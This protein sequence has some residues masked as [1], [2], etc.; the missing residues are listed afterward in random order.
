MKA[1][2][3]IDFG[4]TNTKVTAVDVENKE[5]IG[6]A[7]AFTT[8]KTDVTQGLDNALEK[9]CE[10]VGR[11]NFVE[12]YACSSAAG[13]L[14]MLAVGLVPD[15][16]AEAAKR[17]ALNAGAKV[18][19]TF[20][21]RLND[22]D[23]KEIKSIDPDILLLTGGTDG[24]NSK[25]INYN[26]QVIANIENDFP[27]I[28]AGNRDVS[29]SVA[30][31]LEKQGRDVRVCENVMPEF[32]VLNIEPAKQTIKDLFL[33]RIV[34]AKG[35]TK[36]ESLQNGIL[37]PT[38]SAVLKAVSLLSEG[39]PTNKGLG[40]FMLA[41]IGGA[42]TDVYSAS[43]GICAKT[44]VSF[45]GLPE[46][47]AKRTVEGDLGVRYTLKYLVE[48]VGVEQIAKFAGVEASL[49]EEYL[50]KIEQDP[51][52]IAM[53]G[54][55]QNIDYAFSYF[56]VRLATNRHVGR[57]ETRYTINGVVFVQTGKDLTKLDKVIGTGGPIINSVNPK[58]VLLASLFDE[59]DESVLKPKEFE[60]FLD[61]DYILA[62]M[63]L[64]VEKYP[65]V[66][67]EIMKK[68]IVKI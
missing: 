52:V 42:T 27:V 36:I 40:E 1:V 26:A 3:L 54:E 12:K 9:L 10:K 8:V 48:E 50:D 4:S 60:C 25:V 63:G 46:E 18:L 67:L 7:R 57:V 58:G 64:L 2:L 28:V 37:M 61:K 59:S 21:Y 17:A 56:A 45:K 55:F 34:S 13:G 19:K 65:E 44:N 49:V 6:T 23:V 32:N 14:R 43:D 47:F 62:G 11:I 15:L 68:R 30:K 66:A 38:P 16:T 24:G 39:T 35:L 51:G 53:Q 20:S 33:E 29:G 22:D 5:I 41:D 31:L